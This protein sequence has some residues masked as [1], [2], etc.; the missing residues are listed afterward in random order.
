M[1]KSLSRKVKVGVSFA[2]A[3]QPLRKRRNPSLDL[4]GASNPQ[5]IKRI[6]FSPLMEKLTT[7]QTELTIN[8]PKNTTQKTYTNKY[9]Y[10][11]LPEAQRTQG[12]DSIT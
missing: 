9:W 8:R 2:M 11:T 10:K 1:V 12:I 3:T 7:L 4:S 6:F 5:S